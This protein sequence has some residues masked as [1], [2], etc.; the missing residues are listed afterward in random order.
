MNN[1]INARG[2]ADAFPF[3]LTVPSSD[4]IENAQLPTLQGL[5]PIPVEN[6]GLDRPVAKITKFTAQ[7]GTVQK[8][9]ITD[10]D[11]KSV[12]DKSRSLSLSQAKA[13]VLEFRSTQEL[14]D[15][16]A[17][18]GPKEAYAIGHAAIDK[19]TIVLTDRKHQDF[20]KRLETHGKGIETIS[21]TKRYFSQPPAHIYYPLPIDVDQEP[22]REPITPEKAAADFF[23]IVPELEGCAYIHKP[24]SSSNI[25]DKATDKNLRPG[26]NFH[27]Y[28]V[29]TGNLERFKE[30]YEARSWLA[31]DGHYILSKPNAQTGVQSALERHPIDTAVFSFERLVYEAP[32]AIEPDAPFEYRAPELQV[33]EGRWGNLDDVTELTSEELIRVEELK[34]AA[35][36]AIQPERFASVAEKVRTEK[37]LWDES[38][39]KKEAKERLK[40]ADQGLL[41]PDHVLYPDRG[42]TI[43][44]GE[45]GP[46][47]DGWTFASP[48]RPDAG[49]GKAKYYH[50]SGI[51]HDFKGGE[52]NYR[53]KGRHQQKKSEYPDRAEVVQRFRAEETLSL[54]D[55]P[56]GMFEPLSVPDTDGGSTLYGLNGQKGCGKSQH[57]IT[58]LIRDAL[59]KGK[60]AIVVVPTRNLAVDTAARLT[61]ALG[62]RVPSHLELANTCRD[63]LDGYPVIV[64]CPE[65]LHKFTG[66]QWDICI[67]DEVNEVAPRSW[68]EIL[69]NQGTAS[70]KAL[71]KMISEAEV[72]CIAQDGL[73]QPVLDNIKRL[74]QPVHVEVIQRRRPQ[75]NNVQ[76]NMLSSPEDLLLELVERANNGEKI[77]LPSGSRRFARKAYRFLKKRC[78]QLKT[79]IIDGADSFSKI[80]MEFAAAPDGWIARN[81]PDILIFTP[82]F[83]SGVSIQIP[84]FTAQ[85]EYISPFETSTSA[86]QRGE[87]VRGVLDGSVERHTYIE[88]RGV[89]QKDESIPWE[90]M[91]PEYWLNVFKAAKNEGRRDAIKKAA[92]LNL[93]DA[94]E[95][96]RK[97]PGLMDANPELARVL[98]IQAAETYL[99]REFLTAEWLG[100]GWN[101]VALCPEAKAIAEELGCSLAEASKLLDQY[102][103]HLL[104]KEKK[105]VP[106]RLSGVK[107]MS[108][109]DPHYGVV[110]AHFEAWNKKRSKADDE[111]YIIKREII[112]TQSRARAKA[113]TMA[114]AA[115]TTTFGEFLCAEEAKGPVS[116]AK[117]H[118][119]T[120]EGALGDIKQLHASQFWSSFVY[121]SKGSVRGLQVQALLQIHSE[122]PEEWQTMQEWSTFGK[123]MIAGKTQ[124]TIPEFPVEHRVWQLALLLAQCPMLDKALTGELEQWNK[125]TPGLQLVKKW[126]VQNAARIAGLTSHAGRAK[127]YQFTEKTPKASCFNKLIKMCGIETYEASKDKDGRTYAILTSEAIQNKLD[128]AYRKG[129]SV[130]TIDRLE[131]A[132]YRIE[133]T[134]LIVASTVEHI[135]TRYNSCQ[136]AWADLMA[137]YAV[138]ELQENESSNEVP[139]L[140]EKPEYTIDSHVKKAERV[141]WRGLFKGLIGDGKL[142]LVHWFGDPEPTSVPFGE[143]A[144]A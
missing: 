15:I 88:T 12:K 137:K 14:A 5:E 124:E 52:T 133:N 31:G 108:P 128:N 119:W 73:Y 33:H 81:K 29:V 85:F 34:Q 143:L 126:A 115:N 118:R 35:K 10:E 111:L 41:E 86:S 40:V 54:D 50:E 66:C 11:G 48:M 38:A 47:H 17:S 138:A 19:P 39:I 8:G 67:I 91:E 120:L 46:E 49:R 36:A 101:V 144:P 23:R 24:S 99:K 22:G 27:L 13:E 110:R 121:D 7:N 21:R 114:R 63:A 25:F 72:V 56:V 123:V 74:N 9:F 113:P 97:D 79:F 75:D 136:A 82:V 112:G 62:G 89:P 65:S 122:M 130:R 84:W 68:G 90:T 141:G 58:G 44:A 105:K 69:G 102:R 140:P 127:G 77:V 98:A 53:I 132:A 55:A 142:A 6:Q 57:G 94:V 16:I 129:A 42:G 135:L 80:R 104:I 37:P 30:I 103:V 45:L 20:K 107:P 93:G 28:L 64:T 59:K 4:S 134:P 95:A 87:R 125:D 96:L 71:E 106:E 61:R 18:T 2:H 51:I 26:G 131:A 92:A 1:Q 78:P 109:D 43:K 116:G 32:P 60:N 117:Y 3:S 70:R 76:I 139:P 83:N 100:N